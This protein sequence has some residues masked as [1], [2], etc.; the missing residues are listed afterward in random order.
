MYADELGVSDIRVIPSAQYNKALEQLADLPEDVLD[1]YPILKYRIANIQ[2]NVPTR[3]LKETDCQKCWLGLDDMAVAGG[4]HFPCIIHLREGGD[5]I[6]KVTSNIRQDRL[7]WIK[8]HNALKDPICSK[9]CLDVCR[10]YN[11]TA[12]NRCE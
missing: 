5:P 10:Q 7:N 8:Q 3:G 6:G 9:N 2:N 12:E 4:Y 11:L 1:K